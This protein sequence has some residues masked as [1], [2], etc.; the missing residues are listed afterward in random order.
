MRH[1]LVFLGGEV[2]QVNEEWVQC[3]TI[4]TLLLGYLL[5]SCRQ[6]GQSCGTSIIL[7]P[8]D[9]RQVEMQM[10]VAVMTKTYR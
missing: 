8:Q 6:I 3:V 10:M 2:K 5:Q 9:K 1:F 7:Y 4:S